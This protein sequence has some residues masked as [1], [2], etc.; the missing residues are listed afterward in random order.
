MRASVGF[1]SEMTATLPILPRRRGAHDTL[2]EH[3]C[4]HLST[5]HTCPGLDAL[6]Q[7]CEQLETCGCSFL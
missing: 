3:F 6:F 2:K 5:P 7:D 4:P 1:L